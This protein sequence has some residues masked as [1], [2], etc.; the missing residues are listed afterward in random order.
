MENV[1]G[2][3]AVHNYALQYVW[4]KTS[5]LKKESR[6]HLKADVWLLLLTMI[7]GT[8]FSLV[9]TALHDISPILFLAIRFWTGS[10]FMIPFLLRIKTKINKNHIMHG[11]VLGSFMFLGMVMQTIGLKYTTASKSG[12]ITALTVIF[13]PIL[14]VLINRHLPKLNSLYGVILAAS[15]IYFLTNPLVD[16]LNI[17]DIYTLIGAVCF[18]FQIIFIEKLVQKDSALIMAFFMVLF[19]AIFASIVSALIE[20]VFIELSQK[21][22]LATLGVA[23]FSTAIGFSIQTRWQPQTSATSA[24]VIFTMEP[25]FAFIFAAIFLNERL[26]WLGM[27]GGALILGGTL[28]SELKE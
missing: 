3:R 20:T 6:L 2:L 22:I 15:G 27:A 16:G 13:V 17:G 26:T 9:K 14:V 28:V 1:I 10:L 23:L 24:A 7:W 11:A 12:F 25:V 8:S 4:E 18:A 21:L 5:L 19:T